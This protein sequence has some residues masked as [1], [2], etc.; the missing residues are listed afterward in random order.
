MKFIALVSGGKDSIYSILQCIRNGHEL[1]AAVHLGAPESTDEES[2]MYQTAAS[3]VVKT[4]VEECL[5]VPL[6]LYQRTGKSLNTSLVYDD[7]NKQDEVEDLYNALLEAKSKFDFAAVSSGAVFSTY[8]RVRIENVCRRLQLTSLSYLWR[9]LPQK[10][11]LQKMIVDDDGRI[12]AVLVRTASPPGLLPRKHLNKTLSFLWHTGVLERLHQRYQFHL[13]GEGGEYES[14]VVD[15][16][17]F[18]KK[19]VL[20]EVTIEETDDEVGVLRILKCHAEEKG[21]DDIPILNI[22]EISQGSPSNN[23]AKDSSG[24]GQSDSHDGPSKPQDLKID[25]LPQICESTG[26]LI[27]VSEIMAPCAATQ[28]D[29]DQSQTTTTTEAELAVQEAIQIFSILKKSLQSCGATVQDVMFVHLYLRKMSHFATINAHYEACFGSVLPPSRSC[30]AVG[31]LPGGRRVLLDCMIQKGSGDYMR[32]S[33]SSPLA[34]AARATLTSK[35]RHVLHV[36]SISNWAPVCIGPYS[37][38]NTHRSS[39]HF[40]AGQIGLIPSKMQLHST[41]DQQL[42]QC[43]TN[44]ASVLDALDGVSL[45]QLFSSLIYVVPEIFFSASGM[46]QIERITSKSLAENGTVVAGKIDAAAEDDPYGGYEDEDTMKEMEGDKDDADESD[47][48]FPMLVVAIPEMPMNA[49][50]EVEVAAVTIEVASC[51]DVSGCQCTDTYGNRARASTPK[52]RWDTGHGGPESIESKTEDIRIDAYSRVI[53]HGCAA[54]TFVAASSKATVSRVELQPVDL[55]ADMFA[56]VTKCLS[57][58]RSGLRPRSAIHVRLYHLSAQDDGIHWR[59]ALHSAMASWEGMGAN[60]PAASVV[61]VQGISTINMEGLSKEFSTFLG[62]QVFAI[63][64]VHLQN[65]QL[66][67]TVNR[68]ELL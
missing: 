60:L 23:D 18:K 6:V 17:L 56:T 24:T 26:G 67:Y 38:C 35:L 21:E 52:Q 44:V 20:D 51:L 15:S 50:I 58:A 25:F 66:M 8:Q 59:T 53:G 29:D 62:M 28:N 27:H 4:Q 31:N 12:E 41:W 40:L 10:E 36:Q 14:L 30:V 9:F 61:P 33:G 65:E 45:K 47:A 34:V 55:I 22:N 54:S 46:D 42:T 7:S 64:P 5:Q 48:K 1:V 2:Y 11:M 16:G 57:K 43:W 3:E 13:L 32:S 37:Q 39:L 68:D 49:S 19:L 63:D